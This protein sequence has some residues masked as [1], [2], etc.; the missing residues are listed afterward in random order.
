MVSVIR[1]AYTET[2]AMIEEKAA[3]SM[4]D[5]ARIVGASPRSVYRWASGQSGPRAAARDRLLEVAVVVRELSDTLT[6]DGAHIWLFA[7]NPFLDYARPVDLLGR[8]D[9]RPVLGAI[10]GLKD[11]VFI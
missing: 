2:L 5:V 8:G 9:F 11:G 7:P 10:E 6:P 4:E 3:L 1:T